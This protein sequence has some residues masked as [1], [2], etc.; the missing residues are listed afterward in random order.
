MKRNELRQPYPAHT[1][2][3]RSAPPL[4]IKPKQKPLSFWKVMAGIIV[5]GI[6]IG[7]AVSLAL[8]GLR[9]TGAFHG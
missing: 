9:D 3:W 1:G 2:G 4:P 5:M 7:A 6:I 8:A